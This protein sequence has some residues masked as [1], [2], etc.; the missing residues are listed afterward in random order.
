M[1]TKNAQIIIRL[2]EE[3]KEKLQEI[4]D[5]MGIDMSKL[6]RDKIDEIIKFIDKLYDKYINHIDNDINA[7]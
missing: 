2:S 4:A 1:A 5:N 7:N 6:I 3:K